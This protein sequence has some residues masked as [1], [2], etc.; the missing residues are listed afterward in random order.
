[1]SPLKTMLLAASLMALS[2]CG[3]PQILAGFPT[4]P[5]ELM[6]PPGG[7]ATH[8]LPD[9][10]KLSDVATQHAREATYTRRIEERLR[11]LQQWVREQHA[12]TR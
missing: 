12:V 11:A 10:A 6:T 4:P 5:G 7:L 3:T 8:S 2:G 1:M 9:G